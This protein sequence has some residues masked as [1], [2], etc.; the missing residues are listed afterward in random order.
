MEKEILA[1]LC[2][3][4]PFEGG[5]NEEC[6][7]HLALNEWGVKKQLIKLIEELSELTQAI[8][9]HLNELG[10]ANI[11]EEIADVRIVTE[12][13]VIALDLGDEIYKHKNE[14]LLRLYNKLTKKKESK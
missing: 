6:V 7:Y 2:E 1:Q 9:K 4:M 11:A 5:I 10:N 3:E 13:I 12:Q 14:K 8:T